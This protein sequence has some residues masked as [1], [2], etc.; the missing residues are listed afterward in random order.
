[1][2]IGATADELE[3]IKILTMA[4]GAVLDGG[5]SPSWRD[6]LYEVQ[7]ML[8]QAETREAEPLIKDE[9]IRKAVRAV[10]NITGVSM[11]FYEYYE[12]NEM[13]QLSDM[14]G[15]IL[16]FKSKKLSVKEFD[17]YAIAELCGDE[18]EE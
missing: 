6:V 8:A 15:Q 9:K 7:E 3:K 4:M 18:E 2:K 10:A 5:D 14:N 17:S 1:M 12:D 11:L 16:A 13:I